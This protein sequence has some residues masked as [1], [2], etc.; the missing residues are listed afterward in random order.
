MQLAGQE[1]VST[2][3]L[4]ILGVK[5]AKTMKWD[6]HISDIT[7][8]ASGRL[9]LLS[10]LK[11]FGLSRSDLITIYIGYI[12]PLLEYAVPVWHP[13]L[14]VKQHDSLERIQ[15]RA[16]RIILGMAYV[17]YQQALETCKIVDM[18]QRRDNICLNFAKSLKK[19]RLHSDW[20]TKERSDEIGLELRNSRQLSLPR[21]R[22]QRYAKSA[23]PYMIK[24]W[25]DDKHTC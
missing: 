2:D 21:I 24:L 15:K 20:L 14:T 19:S 10:S 22:T 25:N 3:V 11:R 12:R 5:I 16:C 18:K 4:N 13:G 9:F 7:R 6:I 8:R 23:I 1:L 17:S